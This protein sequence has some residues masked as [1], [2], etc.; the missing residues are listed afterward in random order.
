[1]KQVGSIIFLE[2]DLHAVA[3]GKHGLPRNCGISARHARNVF[4]KAKRQVSSEDHKRQKS[5]V[6]DDPLF[7]KHPELTQAHDLDRRNDIHRI[8]TKPNNCSA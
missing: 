1:M 4:Q 2:T 5:N 6:D 3:G 7:F 8:R